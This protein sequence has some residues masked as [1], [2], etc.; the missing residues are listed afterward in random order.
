MAEEVGFRFVDLR[1]EMSRS[2]RGDASP[3]SRVSVRDF[4]ATDIPTLKQIARTAH[5]GTRF[6][7]DPN[8]SPHRR[9]EYYSTWIRNSCAGFAD[10]V[11]VAETD[12]HAPLGYVSCHIEDPAV[13][14]IG[15]V[16]VAASVRN[17]GVGRALVRASVRWFGERGVSDVRVVTQGGNQPAIRMYE[18]CGFC[19]RELGLWLH[20]WFPHQ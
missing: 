14:R 12:N 1:F 17:R 10:K 8:F 2:T 7:N 6:F 16:G 15:L 11:L 19:P 3:S 18:Q 4:R 9:D 5:R 13:G 20:K